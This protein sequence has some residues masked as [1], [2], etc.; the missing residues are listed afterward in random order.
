MNVDRRRYRVVHR[1][2]YRY[3]A[4]MIDGYSVAHLLPRGNVHSVRPW[5]PNQNGGMSKPILI[6][7]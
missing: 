4:T 3:G 2:D 6:S 7:A 5:T 1:T